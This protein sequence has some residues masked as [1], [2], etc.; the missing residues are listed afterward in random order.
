MCV[1]R[2]T[3]R[4]EELI[5]RGVIFAC[6]LLRKHLPRSIFCCLSIVVVVRM[7]T[8]DIWNRIL[9]QNKNT[10]KQVKRRAA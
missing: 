5:M 1:D 10:K 8:Q 7:H 4:R 9:T 2:E 3:K 6:S